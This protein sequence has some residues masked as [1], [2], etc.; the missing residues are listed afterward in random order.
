MDDEK[1]I[2][3]RV[4]QISTSAQTVEESKNPDECNVYKICKLFL[5]PEE[6]EVLRG[7]YLAWWFSFKEA[8]EYLYE[9]VIAFLKPIQERYNKISDQEIL[10]LLTKN[11]KI[12]NVIAEKKVAE[13]YKKI[14]FSLS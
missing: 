11:A 3:K 4:K 14:G 12:V 8:K 6:N 5:T 2:L 7:K 13:V 1:T 10:D 9:K